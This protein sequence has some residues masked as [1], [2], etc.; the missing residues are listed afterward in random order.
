[1]GR[2][3]M[4]VITDNRERLVNFCQQNDL[5]IGGTLFVH[6]EIHKLTHPQTAGPRTRSTTS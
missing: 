5:V 1:M 2:H 4:G 6:K 3:G